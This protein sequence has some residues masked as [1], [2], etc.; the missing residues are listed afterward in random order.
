MLAFLYFIVV[1]VA[2]FAVLRLSCGPCVLGRIES[3]DGGPG[4]LLPIV[5]MG[6]ALSLFLVATYLVCIAFDLI[7]PQYAMYEVWAPLLPGFVWLTPLSFF[8]GL[9]ESALYGWYVALVFGGLYNVA[10]SWRMQA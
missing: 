7:F 5:P 9:V 4:H 1:A 3:Q 6:W 8:V 10:L 2:I